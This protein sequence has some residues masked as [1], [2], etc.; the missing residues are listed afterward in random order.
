VICDHQI[1]LYHMDVLCMYLFQFFIIPLS[2]REAALLVCQALKSNV[3]VPN[4]DMIR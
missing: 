4:F 1:E 3:S 2:N